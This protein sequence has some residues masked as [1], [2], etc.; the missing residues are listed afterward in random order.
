MANTVTVWVRLNRNFDASVALNDE[1]QG[2]I[3]LV[4]R[5]RG[6]SAAQD[7]DFVFPYNP[8]EFNLGQLSD[9]TAQIARPATTPILAFKSHRLMTVDFT[10]LIAHPGDGLVASVDKELQVLR[11][12]ASSSNKVFELLNYDIFTN[13]PFK[14]RNMSAER[15]NGLFFSITEMTINVT[16][17][18][19]LN[20][21]TQANVNI[22]LIENRNPRM[23]IA[24]ITPLAPIK[25]PDNCK[26]AKYRKNNKDKCKPKKT[27][28]T[29][30]APLLSEQLKA[31]GSAALF[32]TQNCVQVNSQYIC[33]PFG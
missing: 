21:I 13:T 20:Q 11:K 18:N 10:A 33:P 16:R 6:D 22:S 7:E 32:P 26:K 1:P 30:K 19:R 27:D 31:T 3:P 15:N 8:R 12:F 9:E 24:F 5:M 29:P 23:N 2:V 25:P 17:R 14:Y 4:M 28:P